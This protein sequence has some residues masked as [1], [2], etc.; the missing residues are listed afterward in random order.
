MESSEALESWS[1][2]FKINLGNNY[3]IEK[4]KKSDKIEIY[5]KDEKNHE[6]EGFFYKRAKNGNLR[7]YPKGLGGIIE[8]LSIGGKELQFKVEG[9]SILIDEKDKIRI[10]NEKEKD[11]QDS[12]EQKEDEKEKK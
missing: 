7:V 1:E 8:N 4:V 9:Q 11:K 2:I 3:I 6:E 12:N 5:V 10:I